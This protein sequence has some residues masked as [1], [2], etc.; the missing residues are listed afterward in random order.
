MRYVEISVV[1]RILDFIGAVVGLKISARND[2][3]PG[4][5]SC[6]GDSKGYAPPTDE[7]DFRL[8]AY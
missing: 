2:A 5:L 8:D 7:Y 6:A 1:V 4:S 3:H